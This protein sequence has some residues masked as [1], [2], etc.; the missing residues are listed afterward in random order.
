MRYHGEIAT[1]RQR[2]GLRDEQIAQLQNNN[3]TSLNDHD[4]KLGELNSRLKSIEDV[5][6]G[7]QFDTE[8]ARALT[9]VASKNVGVIYFFSDGTVPD[10]QLYCDNISEAFR[11]A[12]WTVHVGM[13]FTVQKAD[14]YDL[15][16]KIKESVKGTDKT[17]VVLEA[18]GAAKLKYEVTYCN[19]RAAEPQDADAQIYVR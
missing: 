10:A 7:R 16:V 4:E 6:D 5:A 2:V 8:L 9:V 15:N 19:P 1:L 12:G 3:S 17:R 18:L 14:G 13:V 11:A